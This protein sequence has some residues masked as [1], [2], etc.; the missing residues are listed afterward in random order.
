M[1]TLYSLSDSRVTA[2]QITPAAAKQPH[3]V[4][5]VNIYPLVT[6]A[7]STRL[8]PVKFTAIDKYIKHTAAHS[9]ITPILTGQLNSLKCI[10]KLDIADD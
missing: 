7:D 3:G 1:H 2:I 6:G 4:H 9:V 5:I 8:A 10:T